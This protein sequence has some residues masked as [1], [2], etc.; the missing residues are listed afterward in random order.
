MEKIKESWRKEYKP[1]KLFK[2]DV[3][4]IINIVDKEF[5]ETATV[6]G[7]KDVTIVVDEFRLDN[8]EELSEIK[9]EVTNK[10]YISADCSS[11]Q[12]NLH[13]SGTTLYVHDKEDARLMGIASMIDEI[14]QEKQ[15]R[16]FALVCT[17]LRAFVISILASLLAG[18]FL[19]FAVFSRSFILTSLFVICLIMIVVDYACHSY[20]SRHFSTIEMA[21]SYERSNFFKRNRDTIL[22][23]VI[24]SIVS[25]ALGVLGTLLVQWVK[26]KF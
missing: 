18:V 23:G 15:R 17:E 25:L 8:M 9:A 10:L 14:I 19:V 24:V 4:K 21:Y 20:I 5:R 13:G 2:D 1:V 22:V 16:F 12:L 3:E 7:D 6:S 26:T 11:L